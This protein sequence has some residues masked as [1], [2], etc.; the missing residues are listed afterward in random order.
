[1]YWYHLKGKT[2]NKITMCIYGNVE[3]YKIVITKRYRDYRS[4]II[5]SISK[6]N[7]YKNKYIYK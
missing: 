2:D 4:N 5:N 1:M 3:I 6:V 7:I